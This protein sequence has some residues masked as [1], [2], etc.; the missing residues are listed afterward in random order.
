[1]LNERDT[2]VPGADL[3]P[4][5]PLVDRRRAALPARGGP[6]AGRHPPPAPGPLPGPGLYG[7]G[8]FFTL[9]GVG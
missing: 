4:H 3:S 5:F 6:A 1:M 7:R 8:L 9:E 2:V